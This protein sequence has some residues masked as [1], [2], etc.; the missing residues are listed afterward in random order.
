ME[1]GATG[2]CLQV[3]FKG[4]RPVTI[5][6][7]G[8]GADEPRPELRGM[9]N[10]PCIMLVQTAAE[11]G[12]LAG[13]DF[14]G[15]GQRF[16]GVNVMEPRHDSCEIPDSLPGLEPAFAPADRSYVAQPSRVACQP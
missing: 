5:A 16:Q 12:G 3:P 10:L 13:V 14:P 9:G 8:G 1:E 2:S 4:Q 7:G 6:E 11:V 15:H